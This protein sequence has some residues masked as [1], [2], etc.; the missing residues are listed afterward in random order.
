MRK[1]ISLIKVIVSLLVLKCGF[2]ASGQTPLNDPHWELVWEDNFDFLNNAW[3]KVG[4]SC[5]HYGEPVLFLIQNVYVSNGNL[6]LKVDYNS[7]NIACSSSWATCGGCQCGSCDINKY[8]PFTSGWVE[9]DPILN[10]QYGYIEAKI[11][12]PYGKGLWP[13]FWTFVGDGL[14]NWHNSAEIDIFEMLGDMDWY[15]KKCILLTL[16]DT[17][18]SLNEEVDY[19]KLQTTNIHRDYC[20]PHCPQ[21][22]YFAMSILPSASDYTHWHKY[23]VEWSPSKIIW[24]VDD[25]PVRIFPNHGII[26]PVRII[27]DIAIQRDSLKNPINSVYSTSFPQYMYVDY[28]KVYSLRKNCNDY[29]YTTQYDFSTYDNIEKNFIKIGSGGGQ[30]S[31]PTGNTI[32]MRASDFIELEGDFTMPLGSSLYMDASGECSTNLFNNNKCQLIFNPCQYNFA[33]YDNKVKKII[34]L[35]GTNCSINVEPNNQ[36]IILQATDKIRIK[37]GTR[38]KPKSNYSVTL[39]INP[40]E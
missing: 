7:S 25:Y 40:C 4:N 2:F 33:N 10:T 8:H 37:N 30:N 5:D 24:Y 6:V 18:C 19:K 34:E 36:N 3:W 27:F 22:D 12:L 16:G 13:A 1:N 29:I 23:A 14:S 9:T 17:I 39:K 20:P 32:Y 15:F 26:D 21:P 11:K 28:V 38:I 31:I 35:G